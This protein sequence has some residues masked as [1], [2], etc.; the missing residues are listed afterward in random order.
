MLVLLCLAASAR[1]Q[2]AA[3]S[4]KQPAASAQ[5]ARSA[6]PA[7]D[8]PVIARVTLK[9]PSEVQR[10]LKLGLDVLETRSG[11]DLFI[12]TTPAEVDQ[13]RIDGWAIRI[14]AD[15][16]ATLQ[17]Q[18]QGQPAPAPAPS[19]PRGSLFRAGYRTVAEMRDLLDER[20]AQ[21][22][23][24]AE[25]FV[26]GASWE[27][28]TGGPT[29][30]HDL[31]G[32][33][34]TNKQRPGPKP[35]FFLMAAIH[36]RELSTSEL[37]LRFVDYL[38]ANYGIDGDATWLL[39]EHAIV[40]VPVVNPD[41]RVLAE[42]GYLQRKNTDTTYGQCPV[43]RFGVDLNRNS[44]FKWGTVNGPTESPC[45]ET[46]PAPA[47]A[48]EPE[49]AA[50]QSLIQSLFPDQRGP[51]DGDPA[52]ANATGTFITL[53]SFG[54]LVL[55]PWGWTSALAPNAAD[56]TA[57]GQKFAAYNGFTPQQSIDLYPTSGTTDDW[58]Y[59]QLG[60]AAFTFEVGGGS[61]AC[62]GFFPDFSCLDG[63][64][65]GAFWPRNLPAFLYAARIARTP[66]ALAHGPTPEAATAS[67]RPD[68]RVDLRVR[69][70][71]V[72]DGGQ[73]IAAAEYYVD[74]PPW[75]G[76]TAIAMTSADGSFDSAVEVAVA[77]IGPLAAKHLIF[78]RGRDS[79]GAWGPVRGVFTPDPTCPAVVSPS[80]QSFGPNGESGTIAVTVASGCAWTVA[81]VE[82]W[83]SI[84]IGA[85]GVGSGSVSY[86]VAVNASGGL[87]TG[88]IAI[89]G[90]SVAIDQGGPAD[91]VETQ[92]S[93]PPGES[94]PGASFSV[95]D[96]VEN[97]G[98]ASAPATIT[99]Y[100]LSATGSKGAGAKLLSGSRSV[101]PLGG[102]G[103]SAGMATVT[104]PSST[105][106]GTYFLVAC[107]DDTNLAREAS[108]T[109][110]CLASGGTIQITRA[111]LVETAVSDPPPAVEPGATFQ[112]T[113]TVVNQ[114]GVD[115]GPST[116]R[117]YLSADPKKGSD[118]LLQ[119]NRQVGMLAAGS[120]STDTAT[121]TVPANTRLGL[122]Y[123]LAC[124]DDSTAVAEVNEKNNCLAAAKRVH[125]ARAD[126]IETAVS[127]PPLSAAPG[128]SFSVTDRVANQ[129]AVSASASTTRYYLSVD[130]RRS[131]G[132]RRLTGS[133]S[134]PVLPAAAEATDTTVVT[135]PSGTP[136]GNYYLLACANDAM[137]A[138]NESSETNNC[139][140]SVQRVAVGP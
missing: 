128:A 80:S 135:I 112:V 72:S 32:I 25:V 51:G 15:H 138:V 42:A 83:I 1:A 134:V 107:A 137:P 56:L 20:A 68:G 39:D 123:M 38:L 96:T 92:V 101:P 93:E 8:E 88:A 78:A 90:Q 19:A 105:P 87:R 59:G 54:D 110:N 49:T 47:A 46:Y 126:L 52:P 9:T 2:P 115:A 34:L 26:Y 7:A 41:G 75:S 60:I 45:S 98:G 64:A 69:L 65:D 37:A 121:V 76:G 120:A 84:P 62:G 122:Y 18:R 82:P 99:R 11:D 36:A 43:P 102:N 23:D 77:T 57:I 66:Y 97:L 67:L 119:G 133:R 17:R 28:L 111:D 13:L 61:G 130:K 100:Y 6:A 91:L 85:G 108:E 10:F 95:I 48:S 50:V 71:D 81:T 127:D 70:D 27:R 117:Y 136:A 103:T 55:W 21:Y 24:L 16:S 74:A 22:P 109:D 79:S 113:D 124:A 29:A 132:D 73:P 12:L 40:V 118:K 116:T 31:F 86:A 14:D 131:S 129:S 94:A 30:G 58:A 139:I 125:V 33:T 63:G 5:L 53:H 35:T 3:D 44:S 106:L 114:G 140:A 4:L 104:V 89:A